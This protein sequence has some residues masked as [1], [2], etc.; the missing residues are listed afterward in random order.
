M[1]RHLVSTS[2][3][4]HVAA[5]SWDFFERLRMGHYT[6]LLTPLFSTSDLV[7]DVEEYTPAFQEATHFFT[8]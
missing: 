7:K 6:M 3:F 4:L 8:I 5:P 1:P 2:P